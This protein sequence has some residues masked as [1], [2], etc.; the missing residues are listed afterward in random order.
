MEIRKVQ[1]SEYRSLAKNN[2]YFLWSFLQREQVKGTLTIWSLFDEKIGPYTGVEN[3]IIDFLKVFPISFYESYL[4]ESV[5]FLS[6]FGI[7]PQILYTV[8]LNSD[9]WWTRQRRMFYNPVIVLF[10]KYQI[11]GTTFDK[12]YCVEGITEL[13][14]EKAPE[15]AENFKLN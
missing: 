1:V 10:K 7:S 9:A 15:L 8:P 12:C 5:D 6:G 2:D 13:I 11:L 14:L 4:D 3:Q